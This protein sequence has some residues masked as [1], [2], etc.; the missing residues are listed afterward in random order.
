[1]GVDLVFTTVESL[2]KTANILL[3]LYPQV[4]TQSYQTN[5][6]E[7]NSQRYRLQNKWRRGRKT[8][9]GKIDPALML[10]SLQHNSS[11]N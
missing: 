7:R 3:Q 4:K 8:C 10:T 9:V 11:C 2:L 1:M 5:S 6:T